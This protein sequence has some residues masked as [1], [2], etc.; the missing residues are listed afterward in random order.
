MKKDEAV[1][2]I[3]QWQDR[4]NRIEGIEREFE[5]EVLSAMG[6][7]PIKIITGFRRTG[8]SF[9]AQR[10]ARRLV[11]SG[12]F[13]LSNILYL[14]FEDFR[15]STINSPDKLDSVYRAF[16][17]E[18]ATDGKKLLIF[19]EVQNVK[20]WDRFIRTV[21]ET[22]SDAE[23]LLT[24]SNS[25]LL[26]SEIGSRLAGRVIEF[27]ILPFDFIEYLRFYGISVTNSVDYYRQQEK[28]EH[29]FNR[30]LRFGGLPETL[31]I[32]SDTACFSYL[33]GVLSK[34]VLDDILQRFNIKHST[35]I[36]KILLYLFSA[37]GNIVSFTRISNYLKQ[38]DIG[39]KQETLI[40]YIQYMLK[41][42][43]VYEV[44]K[45]DWKLGKIFS[46]TRKYYAVDTG[47]INLYPTTVRNLSN[48]LENIV[49]LNLKK[50]RHPI[51][52][53][54][55]ASGK[56]IDFIQQTESGIFRKYQVSQTL[57]PDNYQR[58]LSP[59]VLQGTYLEKGKNTLLTLDEDEKDIEF[60]TCSI[61]KKNILRWLLKL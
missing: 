9:L 45:F 31:S 3:A 14:N 47:L 38:L 22:D 12:A 59:F 18:I 7:K 8:K 61:S 11:E 13:S 25:E 1:Q 36:E 44:S 58:E 26:S 5:G 56:E 23:I 46:T 24:G 60:Q 15:L 39:I 49:F 43:A 41:S 32:N 53:G 52:F 40:K 54:A 37:V 16:R 4:L 51:Y 35:A 6:S 17:A 34:V 20:Q 30:Y 28:I 48:Q 2:L 27:S 33:E 29:Y 42:F 21:Y 55:R 50:Q 57:H 10:V 19:D